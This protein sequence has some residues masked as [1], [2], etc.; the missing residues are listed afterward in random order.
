MEKPMIR[1]SL[2]GSDRSFLFKYMKEGAVG[3]E[4]GVWKGELSAAI[5]EYTKPSELHLIDPWIAYKTAHGVLKE[6][7]TRDGAE[8]DRHGYVLKRFANDINQGKVVVHKQ[9][10]VEAAVKF[11]EHQFDWI[12]VDGGHTYE[13]V[14]QDLSTYFDK[15]KV[16][17]YI[18]G[19]DYNPNAWK[20]VVQAVDEFRL[21]SE[22]KTIDV[23]NPACQFVLQRIA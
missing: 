18:I 11:T 23:A 7:D 2:N 14:K 20:G 10:A 21:K 4:I 19:D 8:D 6:E 13:D 22:I 12:Y 3:A 17:G 5:L 9:F 15:I 1:T 16:G